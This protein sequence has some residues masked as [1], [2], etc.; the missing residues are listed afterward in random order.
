M[1]ALQNLPDGYKKI[2]S[3]NFQEDKKTAVWINISALIIAAALAI[4]MHFKVSV[5][6]LFDMS[7]GLGSYAV[8]FICIAVFLV[9]YMVLHELVHGAAMK[10]CG[11]KKV[12]YGF[13]GLYAFAGSEDFYDKRSYLF[14][15]LAPIVL[16]GIVLAVINAVVPLEWFWVIY[17]VQITNI[18]GAAGDLYVTL[19]FSKLPKDILVCDSGVSMCVY[20]K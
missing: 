1:R 7:K 12:K 15:A 2:L 14:I 4:P 17:L 3:I 11:T 9:L 13:T 6:T 19:K 16:W 20:S 8:R 10:I 18:S 5:A